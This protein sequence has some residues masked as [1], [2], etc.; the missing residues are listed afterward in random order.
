MWEPFQRSMHHSCSYGGQSEQGGKTGLC[1]Q[2]GTGSE[3]PA[4][5]EKKDSIHSRQ[6]GHG[7]GKARNGEGRKCEEVVALVRGTRK[8]KALEWQ[9]R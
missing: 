1:N 7:V 8:A 4:R 6:Q 9:Q 2:R 5:N 3:E